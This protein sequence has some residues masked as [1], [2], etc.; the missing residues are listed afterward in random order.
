MNESER[1]TNCGPFMHI[2]LAVLLKMHF[3]FC[4]PEPKKNLLSHILLLDKPSLPECLF[5][6]RTLTRPCTQSCLPGYLFFFF[7]FSAQLSLL[8]HQPAVPISAL[9]FLSG[10]RT[11]QMADFLAYMSSFPRSFEYY[12]ICWYYQCVVCARTSI[13]TQLISA[14]LEHAI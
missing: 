4:T 12:G 11:F 1:W 14:N 8:Q 2:C 3:V 7:F 9:S 6:C 13:M 5:R 10:F